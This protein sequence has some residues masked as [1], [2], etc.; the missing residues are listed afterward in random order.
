MKKLYNRYD[1]YEV[2]F[3]FAPDSET[4]VLL[5]LEKQAEL[6]MRKDLSIIIRSDQFIPEGMPAF[7]NRIFPEKITP[8]HMHDYCEIN[9][10]LDGRLAQYINTE[11][12]IM[13]KG[14]ILIMNPD[15]FHA[16][17]PI[18]DTHANNLLI[19]DSI[20][21]NVISMLS[22]DKSPNYLSTLM[23]NHEYLI[24]R[25]TEGTEV[26]ET[27]KVISDLFSSNK[28]DKKF[29]KAKAK[30]LTERLLIQLADCECSGYHAL[31]NASD[32]ESRDKRIISYITEHF[33]IINLADVA[34]H[35]GYSE[36]QIRRIVKKNT[37]LSYNIYL[38]QCRMY[39][40]SNLLET[41]NIPVNEIAHSVGYDSPEYFSRRFKAEY[42][43][44]PIEYR[45]K[46]KNTSGK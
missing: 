43:K 22:S 27:L 11:K 6:T 14:D 35:F 4:E 8:Y 10:V 42:D 20:I 17:H 23:R 31:G 37:G 25:N 45:N 18:G 32:A 9:Y 38:R 7:V 33:N 3:T 13:Q 36:Q 29:L 5:M 46:Y 34:S 28:S 1:S 19:S 44:S 30:N 24:F 40:A 26:F 16:S 39:K 21:K 2:D 12:Y 15:I 41:T